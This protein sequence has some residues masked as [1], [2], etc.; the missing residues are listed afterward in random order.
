[1][2]TKHTQDCGCTTMRP[3]LGRGV[4]ERPLWENDITINLG[5][6]GA[7]TMTARPSHW[8][9]RKREAR[10]TEADS[11]ESPDVRTWRREGRT[12]TQAPGSHTPSVRDAAR[13]RSA[14]NPGPGD[15]RCPPPAAADSVRATHRETPRPADGGRA[16]PAAAGKASFPGPPPAPAWSAPP[17]PSGPASYLHGPDQAPAGQLALPQLQQNVSGPR[18]AAPSAPSRHRCRRPSPSAGPRPSRRRRRRHVSSSDKQEASGPRAAEIST[19]RQRGRRSAPS[20]PSVEAQA[21]WQGLCAPRRLLGNV[22]LV[23]GGGGA[24]RTLLPR[25]LFGPLGAL[26]RRR[27][28]PGLGRVLLAHSP[29]SCLFWDVKAN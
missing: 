20:G 23:P 17:R 9:R 26:F 19:G 11:P 18:P 29:I 8:T 2:W 7:G 15:G 27:G 5:H 3:P 12:Q 13:P 14:P 4:Q 22:V 21:A 28:P 10:R 25:L 6:G 24:L 16:R 1:M